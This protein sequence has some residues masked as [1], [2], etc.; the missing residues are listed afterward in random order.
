[1][2]STIPPA[3]ILVT[4]DNGLRGTVAMPT[5]S[6][7]ASATV[8][9]VLTDGRR[10]VV[11]AGLLQLRSDGSYYLPLGPADIATA[12]ATHAAVAVTHATAVAATHATPAADVEVTPGARAAL[13]STVDAAERA[14]IP[15]IAEQVELHKRRVETGKVRITKRVE[16]EEQ[17]VDVPLQ[18]E[19]VVVERVPVERFVTETP[20]VRHEGDTMIVPVME[21]VLVVEKRLMVRE[22]LR[23]TTRRTET[24]EPRTV[25]LRKEVA[26]VERTATT[27]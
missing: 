20:P 16:V 25:S 2:T 7:P 17:L 23:L 18:R 3:A 19:E 15:L 21:E 5:P 11:P 13:G 27:E 14:V 22:E 4:G 24:H 8:T 1:M 12:T 10:V 26:H 6:G 9:V